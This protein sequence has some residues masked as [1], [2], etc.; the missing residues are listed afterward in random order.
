MT[1]KAISLC[2]YRQNSHCLIFFLM[3]QGSDS[4]IS[5]QKQFEADSVKYN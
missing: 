5:E 4:L 2:F 3:Q 1:L